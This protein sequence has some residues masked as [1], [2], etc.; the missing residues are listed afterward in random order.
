MSAKIA[1]ATVSGKEYY[2][3]V[4]ELKR[5][6]LFFISL[7][8]GDPIPPSTRVV[9]TTNEE[10]S[11]IEHPNILT[12]E[13]TVD[14]S[15]LMNEAIRIIRSKNLYEKVV[16]GVDPGKTFGIAVIADGQTLKTED[17]LG[18]EKT[19]DTIL[20]EL[21]QNPGKT[22]KIKIGSGVPELAEEL[23]R[24]LRRILSEN[25]I[26]EIVGEA[27]TSTVREKGSRKKLSDADSA[28]RIA[29]ESET[30]RFRRTL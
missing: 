29:S 14:P 26:I 27:G 10:K 28:K 30:V 6:K 25:I 2:S 16:I 5:R 15:N 1:V 7:V 19:V 4:T 24:R 22:Q 3:L 11:L 21:K 23:I 20:T 17:G 13:H 18:L 12:Y 8:P 9:V